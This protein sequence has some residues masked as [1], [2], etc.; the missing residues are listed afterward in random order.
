MP[1]RPSARRTTGDP[2]HGNPARSGSAAGMLQLRR[3][4]E[5]G[6]RQPALAPGRGLRWTKAT[7]SDQRP[8]YFRYDWA[9]KGRDPHPPQ[10][11]QQRGLLRPRDAAKPR[12]GAL[13]SCAAVPLLRHGAR[14]SDG[15]GIWRGH[16]FS[17]RRLRCAGD[18]RGAGGGAL[19]RGARRTDDVAAMLDHPEFPRFDLSTMRTGIMAGA[20]CPVSLMRRVVRDMYCREIT[21]AYGMTETSPISFQS[22]VDDSIERRISTVGESCRMSK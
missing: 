20:P 8:V 21:I 1:A 16:G 5:P 10:H 18:A 9:P 15:G 2:A 3:G 11:H 4:H 17:R 7:R 22:N 19:H 6:R 12:R 14:K 13:H